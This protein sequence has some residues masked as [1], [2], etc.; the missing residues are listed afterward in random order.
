MK[1]AEKIIKLIE[2]GDPIPILAEA[3]VVDCFNELL[4]YELIDIVN[5]K[6]ILTQ[7]GEQAR[8]TGLDQFLQELKTKE[9]LKDF[10]PEIQIKEHAKF[11]WFLALCLSLIVFVIAVSLTDCTVNL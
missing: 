3:G 11:R 9:E 10:S 8:I 4:R 1:P 7:K 6:V 2:K 5:E